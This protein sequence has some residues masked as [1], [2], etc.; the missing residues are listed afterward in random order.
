MVVK[1]FGCCLGVE[2]LQ[3]IGHVMLLCCLVTVSW[4]ALR[5]MRLFGSFVDFDRLTRK[6]QIVWVLYGQASR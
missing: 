1:Q 5:A 2:P 3:R 4:F 6:Q